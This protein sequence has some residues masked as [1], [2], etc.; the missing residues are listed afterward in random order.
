[1]AR[2]NTGKVR[3]VV[4]EKSKR[5][6]SVINIPA[7]SNDLVSAYG[8]SVRVS[9][10]KSEPRKQRSLN[11]LREGNDTDPRPLSLEI[12]TSGGDIQALKE[13]SDGILGESESFIRSSP[14]KLAKAPVDYSKF[15]IEVADD[16]SSLTENEDTYTDLSG[17]IVSDSDSTADESDSHELH[18]GR[19]HP[20]KK[21]FSSRSLPSLTPPKDPPLLEKTHKLPS[22]KFDEQEPSQTDDSPTDDLQ[23]VIVLR[24][25]QSPSKQLRIP[26][27]P[28]RPSIDAFWSQDVIN[29]WNDQYSPKKTPKSRCRKPLILDDYSVSKAPPSGPSSKS[30]TKS[31]AKKDKASL[32]K[33]RA[34][35]ERKH[36]MA[37]CF[38]TEVDQIISNS[39]V[40]QMSESTGGIKIIWSKKLT[41]TAGR[42][43]WR[44]EAIRHKHTD[45]TTSETTHRHHASIEL[46]E[47]VIDDEERLTNVL[48]H[49]YCHLANFMISGVK[50]NPHGK[51][52]KQWAARCTKA[53]QDRGVQV[54]T[55][56]SYEISYKYIWSCSNLECGTEYKRHSKSIDPAKHSCGACKGK[57][58]QIRPVPRKGAAEGKRSEYQDFVKREH[59]RTKKANPG[60]SF[61]EIMAILGREFRKRKM[62]GAEAMKVLPTKD[63]VDN[64]M[65]ELKHLELGD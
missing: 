36:D 13:V 45:G 18:A 46:A 43:N 50:D 7:P 16:E 19:W 47:K 29:D 56:H 44:R 48:A 53:F 37:T 49:E 20:P 28:H 23:S 10:K 57:L 11:H 9:T 14:R 63:A 54:N 15:V 42:A 39:Q 27:M 5:Q 32:A 6:T 8:E 1:M 40:T 61:G 59:E 21:I 51:E 62:S 31:A 65:N 26:P 25:L 58:M 55:K 2:L 41:S 52:F 17:F 3:P 34:F 38:L 12:Q 4:A 30:P 24:R 33:H 22:A 64:M 35:N 60:A